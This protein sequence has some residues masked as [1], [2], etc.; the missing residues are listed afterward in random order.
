[1]PRGATAAP[2]EHNKHGRRKRTGF[3]E[4][5]ELSELTNFGKKMGKFGL[6]PCAIPTDG[7]SEDETILNSFG[8]GAKPSRRIFGAKISVSF[9]EGPT[10]FQG[11]QP[12]VGQ[13]HRKSLTN[14]GILS[15]GQI[16]TRTLQNS[17]APTPEHG[18]DPEQNPHP[19][20]SEG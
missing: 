5:R 15:T 1:M 18:E 10:V 6:S 14:S 8:E 2:P 9:R 20:L 13:M 4:S 12:R 3:W 11:T 7:I 19:L 17:E 16:H